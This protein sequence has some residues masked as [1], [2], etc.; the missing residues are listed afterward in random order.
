[1]SKKITRIQFLQEKYKKWEDLFK[2]YLPD[3]DYKE[4]FED[5]FEQI[6]SLLC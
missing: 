1:M 5:I 6:K 4:A 3:K 2:K